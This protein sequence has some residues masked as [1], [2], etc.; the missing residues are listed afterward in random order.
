M[1]Q[2]LEWIA[3]Y[4]AQLAA[5][6]VIGLTGAGLQVNFPIVGGSFSG[7]R[8]SAKVRAIGADWLC[9][10]SDGVGRMDVRATLETEHGVLIDVRYSGVVD[11]GSSGQQDFINNRLPAVVQLRAA[12]LMRCAHPDFDWVNR[13]QFVAIGEAD[14]ASLTA[15]YKLYALR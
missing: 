13:R 8:L 11:L 1:D 14:M 10:G 3:D 15:R 4:Q 2:A 7:A 6:E 5:P 9:V 12:P